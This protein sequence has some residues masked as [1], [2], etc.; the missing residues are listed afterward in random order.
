MGGVVLFAVGLL[1][2]AS[3][4]KASRIELAGFQVHPAVL[5]GFLALPFAG[6]RARLFPSSLRRGFSAFA[7]CLWLVTVVDDRVALSPAIKLTTTLA[8]IF[9]VFSLV[10][11]DADYTSAVLGFGLGVAGIGVLGILSGDVGT[12][13]F[14]PLASIGNKNAYSLFGLPCILVCAELA[15]RR[16]QP[17]TLRALL[18]GASGIV[19]LVI[20]L[21]ANRSGWVSAALIGL[22]LMVNRGGRLRNAAL[23]TLLVGAVFFV[24]TE[25]FDTG[26][27]ERRVTQTLEGYQSDTFR[28]ALFKNSFFIGLDHPLLGAGPGSF[29]FELAS[30]VREFDDLEQIS[31]HNALT[32]IF[33]MGGLVLVVGWLMAGRALWRLK[34]S[35]GSTPLVRI[36]LILWVVRSIFSDETLYAPAFAFAFG[37]AIADAVLSSERSAGMAPGRARPSAATLTEATSQP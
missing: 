35:A 2:F 23:V 26:V 17:M 29:G 18:L 37:L 25:F 5:L 10:R 36:T 34:A 8:F 9:V 6:A 11:S 27:F 4:G 22:M 14:N 33:G 12:E 3:R 1:F 24:L 21:S 28:I 30:R 13:T 19:V 20:F 32:Y 31:P 16:G 15:L 7:G